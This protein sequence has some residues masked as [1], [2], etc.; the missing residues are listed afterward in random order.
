MSTTRRPRSS[1]DPN[2]RE[3]IITAALAVIGRQGLSGLTHRAVAAEAAVPLGSTTYYFATL[4]D[5]LEAALE[6]A[7]SNYEAALQAW[8]NALPEVERRY[9]V[10]ALTEM[11]MEYL[12]SDREH[13]V[14]EYELYLAAMSRPR[15][16]TAASRY[17]GTTIRVLSALT[18]PDTASAL[19]AAIDGLC[20]RALTNNE[21]LQHADVRSV[22]AAI[23]PPAR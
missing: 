17:T 18:T 9:P 15:L 21:P 3:R 5:L 6:R 2:R 4:D 20:I 16:R 14:V 11:V 1:A 13:L 7:V 22:L 10:D 12:A 8:S 19:T 23:L